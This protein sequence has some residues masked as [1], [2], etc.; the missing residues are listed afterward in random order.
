M[1]RKHRLT[2]KPFLLSAPGSTPVI[3]GGVIEGAFY[4]HD[5]I[6][7]PLGIQVAEAV[8]R[9]WALSFVNFCGDARKAGWKDKKITSVI[10]EALLFNGVSDKEQKLSLGV[11]M[12]E[13]EP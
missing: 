5:T 13:I 10:R 12:K 3:M 6:G 11:I 9:G 8:K 1:N 2:I 7:L 4:F